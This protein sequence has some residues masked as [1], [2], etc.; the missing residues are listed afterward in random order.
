ESVLVR[1]LT[2]TDLGRLVAVWSD[3]PKQ[4]NDH[5]QLSVGDYFDI[6][7]RS[8]SLERRGAYLPSL[9]PTYI[10]AYVPGRLDVGVV[11]ANFLRTLGVQPQV[12]RDFTPD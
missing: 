6:Q 5:Y 3:N 8:H 10:A 7:R 1:G 11:T 4:H 12:G 9:N 2:Y